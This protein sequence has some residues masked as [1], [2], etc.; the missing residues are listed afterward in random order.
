MIKKTI[1][2]NKVLVNDSSKR[3]DKNVAEQRW[4]LK[5]QRPLSQ[6]RGSFNYLDCILKSSYA[7]TC[8]M[9]PNVLPIFLEGQVRFCNSMKGKRGSEGHE[10]PLNCNPCAEKT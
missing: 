10:R 1:A 7:F 3:Y 5:H 6:C 9:L 8:E 2:R 4:N